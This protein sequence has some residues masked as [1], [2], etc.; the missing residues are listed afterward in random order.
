M[1]LSTQ[2]ANTLWKLRPPFARPGQLLFTYTNDGLTNY[3][4]TVSL[5][6]GEPA[7]SPG[8]GVVKEIYRAFPAWQT[9]DAL[10]LST[11]S[12]HVVLDHGNSVITTVGGL[13]AAQVTVGQTVLRGDLLGGL[14][15]SQMYFSVTV[16]SK[17]VNPMA[18]SSHWQMQN[19]N[20]VT[21]QGGNI[22][23]APDRLLRDFSNNVSVLLN[24]GR[25]YFNNLTGFAP[26]LINVDFNGDGSK[27]GAGVVGTVGDYWNVYAPVNFNATLASGCTNYTFSYYAFSAEVVL[28]LQAAGACASSVLLERVAPLFSAAGS[29]TSWDS[30]LKTWIGGYL[31]PVPYENTFK[32]RGLP[33]GNY[34]LYLYAD[35]GSAPAASTFYAAVNAGTPTALANTPFATTVY[36]QNCNYVVYNFSVPLGGSITFKAV[37]YLSGLQLQRV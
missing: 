2:T 1:N 16:G 21:G 26:L 23:F 7:V 11:A 8:V 28:S 29:G 37:G 13:S 35:R 6:A 15:G 34:N 25:H 32:L 31:G 33:A 10:V 24:N 22:R 30:M 27:T 9:S 4:I 20:V 5:P 17:T 19:S 3:G 18:L 14:L 12:T 36:T